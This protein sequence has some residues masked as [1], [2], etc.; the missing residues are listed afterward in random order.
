[1][2]TEQ[3]KGMIDSLSRMGVK[4]IGFTGGEPLL[5]RDIGEILDYAKSKGMKT[6]LFSNG[7]LVPRMIDELKSL[8][9]LLLSFD[10]PREVQDNQRMNGA[11]DSVVKAIKVAKK[12]RIKVWT[13][14]VITKENVKHIPFI[15]KQGKKWGVSS[16]F[17]PVFEYSITADK[18]IIKKMSSDIPLFR[19]A[20]NGLIKAKKAGYSI[21]N[22]ASYFRYLL[23]YWPQDH[24]EK[25]YAGKLFCAINCDGSVAPCHYLMKSKDWPNGLKVGWKKAV[26]N[27]TLI[28]CKGCYGNAYVDSNLFFSLNPEVIYNAFRMY[29]F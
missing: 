19:K 24:F 7:A 1:M 12:A 8:D 23:K 13:N 9:L 10:G 20:I 27:A 14:T 28:S 3:V 11:Y 6:T 18:E 25:C 26:K 4:R 5:R 15:L 17:M 21:I 2:T 22:S 29:R 16:M